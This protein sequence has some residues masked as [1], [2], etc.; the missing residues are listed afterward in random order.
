MNSFG[1]RFIW[2]LTGSSL[3]ATAQLVT[4]IAL[5]RLGGPL[6]IGD[7]GLA[8]AVMSP[9]FMLAHLELR[10]VVA[11]D[12]DQRFEL[13]DGLRLQLL[14]GGLAIGA[15]AIVGWVWLPAEAGLL[16]AVGVKRLFES[17]GEV[18]FGAFQRR[19]REA[20]IATSLAVR[21]A[22]D[23][24]VVVAVYSIS[25][26]LTVAV[27]AASAASL[28]VLVA[29]DLPAAE[30]HS[31]ATVWR[32]RG[33]RG[34][35]ALGAYSAPAGV[36]AM[37]T[38]L[39][40]NIPRYFIEHYHGR[41]ALGYFVPLL[42]LLQV[43]VFVNAALSQA[44]LPA[45]AEKY[46]TSVRDFRVALARLCAVQFAVQLVP[47]GLMALIGARVLALLYKPE[48]AQYAG[49]SVLLFAGGA[50]RAIT[51]G[52]A[53]AQTVLGILHKE[54][55]TTGVSLVATLALCGLL[56]P[57][58]GLVGAAIVLSIAAAINVALG[59]RVVAVAL[60]TRPS[61]VSQGR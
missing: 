7:Y 38:S 24:G 51:A 27:L 54:A 36:T 57:Q 61:N 47:M 46:R 34:P 5:T 4:T 49:V 60:A 25:R 23:V 11:T 39:N 16:L 29:L 15:L 58:F 44:A 21:S 52:L 33:R 42:Q 22:A 45:L 6:V 28:L 48:Y 14:T 59:A 1:W 32:S 40:S 9:L 53:V 8:Q 2:V 37:M 20:R 13:G 41:A 26:S 18:V 17:L 56:I 55:V 12:V 3:Y 31:S 50:V 10:R 35:L 30:R 19:H 43:G